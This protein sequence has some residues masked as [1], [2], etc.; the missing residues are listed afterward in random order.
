[1]PK[2][3]HQ[4]LDTVDPILNTLTVSLP[5]VPFSMSLLYLLQVMHAEPR[6][7]LR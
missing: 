7:I 5:Y 2:M 6:P 3:I 4:V 1:M